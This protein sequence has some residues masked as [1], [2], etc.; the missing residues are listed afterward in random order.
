MRV[1][2][3]N[4]TRGYLDNGTTNSPQRTAKNDNKD[5]LNK[6]INYNCKVTVNSTTGRIR[7][8]VPTHLRNIAQDM[9]A[10]YEI[11]RIS[12]GKVYIGKSSK[13]VKRLY[14]WTYA[15]NNPHSKDGM[16]DVAQA[17]RANP[18]DIKVRIIKF[19]RTPRKASRIEKSEIN[20]VKAISGKAGLFNKISGG[21][22]GTS[23]P[24]KDPDADPADFIPSV[25][26]TPTK[27]WK[28]DIDP[29]TGK[30]RPKL[31]P[32]AREKKNAIYMW[33]NTELPDRLVG[34]T[35]QLLPKRLTN[36]F[37]DESTTDGKGKIREVM[38]ENAD[39]GEW[40]VASL[41]ELDDPTYI[42]EAE[43]A[44]A[45]YKED[46]GRVLHNCNAGGGGSC[47]VG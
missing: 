9:H 17:I 45:A 11:S 8:F 36:Y 7:L 44:A 14:N 39:V 3:N 20:R 4:P 32:S 13:V 37:G 12:D 10:V 42:R 15:V 41:A 1:L 23:H 22:G 16:R 40:Y 2:S 26:D 46:Q 19:C 27:K 47:A 30:I 33:G 38:L 43:I 21:G 28:V 18:Q 29:E 31:T 25:Y 24:V 34:Y 6:K 5:N 35:T